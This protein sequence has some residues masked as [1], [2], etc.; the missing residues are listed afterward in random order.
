MNAARPSNHL[1][2]LK[3]LCHASDLGGPTKPVKTHL[4]WTDLVMEE[5]YDQAA[6]ELANGKE[7]PSLPVRG[8]VN[9][10]KFQ[11]AFIGFIH[12]L[13][14]KINAIPGIDFETPLRNVDVVRN[15]WNAQLNAPAPVSL[16]AL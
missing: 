9:L 6:K 13:F 14:A 7:K 10:G 1:Q 4:R 12:P 8:S 2:V 11:L 16:P 5:F 3:T 15:H